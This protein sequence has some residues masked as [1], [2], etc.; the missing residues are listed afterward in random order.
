MNHRTILQSPV[1]KV[2]DDPL[3]LLPPPTVVAVFELRKAQVEQ[4]LAERCFA[5][6]GGCLGESRELRPRG[7]RFSSA[8]IVHANTLD[9]EPSVASHWE[10]PPA[11]SKAVRKMS[12]E[13]CPTSATIGTAGCPDLSP[14]TGS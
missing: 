4:R 6:D 11:T 3:L 13:K 14:L 12:R 5:P 1:V 9:S 2:F 7:G 10:L 8:A